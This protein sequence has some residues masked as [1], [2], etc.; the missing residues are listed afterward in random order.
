MCLVTVCAGCRVYTLYALM[1]EDLQP[2]TIGSTIALLLL[3]RTGIMGSFKA[4]DSQSYR[5]HHL[6]SIPAAHFLC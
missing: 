1:S 6:A 4:P 3:N 5:L 2:T